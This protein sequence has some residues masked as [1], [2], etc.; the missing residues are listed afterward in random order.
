MV[1][2][3]EAAAALAAAYRE[4]EL[5]QAVREH[6][7]LQAAEAAAASGAGPSGPSGAAAAA[8]AA[9]PH[10]GVNSKKR[11][12]EDDLAEDAHPRGLKKP[13]VDGDN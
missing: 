6:R 4:E 8:A 13:K 1:I 5:A 3:D 12:A 10:G 2:A 9:S 7:E 11:K